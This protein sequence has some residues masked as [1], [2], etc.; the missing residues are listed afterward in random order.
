MT[1]MRKKKRALIKGNVEA[2]AADQ[3]DGKSI[4]IRMYRVGF[5]DCFLLSIPT[6]KG[7]STD[8]QQH[9]L[10][11]CGVHS[12]GDIG[13]IEKVVNNI[14]EVT[15][16]KL[17]VIIATHAHQDHISGFSKFGDMFSKFKVGEVWLPWTWDESNKEALKI[18]KIH[19]ALTAQLFQHFEALGRDVNQNAMYALENLNLSGNKHAIELLKSGFG[20]DE[21][22]VRYLKAGDILNSEDIS[23][24]GLFVRI[25]GPPESEEFL[26][27]MNPPSS[28]RYLRMVDGKA[29]IANVIQP[30]VQRWK[31]D[32]KKLTAIHLDIDEEKELQNLAKLSLDDLAFTLDQARNNES[33]VTLFIFHNQQ[34]LL[35]AGDAQYG[36]WKWWLENEQS[37]DIL[38]KINF[39]KIAHHGSHNATP[40]TALEGMTDGE[41]AAM[42]STQS[43]P[44]D[45]IP[46]D[47]LMARLN[48]KTRKHI[49]RSDWLSVEGA[50]GPI[51][52]AEPPSPSMLPKG[53]R[54]GDLWF[55][56]VIKL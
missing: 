45:S 9:I 16:K 49:V 13:T 46:R 30:F 47:P 44:W 41:F 4:R 42:V 7:Q 24:P 20:D 48:E 37:D 55:D 3:L 19:A 34:H 36:N 22:K 10:V 26:A 8:R 28:Q 54:K 25:L 12:R 31:V 21:A 40:K 29:E 1:T 27:Q 15:D 50:P 51:A 38:S 6:A 56:Y 5:G 17:A 18:Q 52:H 35:F 32:P 33:L 23:I 11:D 14:G 2:A 39:F 43:K 53:F